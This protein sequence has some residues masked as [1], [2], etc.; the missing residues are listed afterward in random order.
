MGDADAGGGRGRSVADEH[1]L[2]AARILLGDMDVRWEPM[3]AG[4][5]ACNAMSAY[6]AQ[7]SGAGAGVDGRV[8]V[9]AG[10]PVRIRGR[11]RWGV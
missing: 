2:R 5:S 1:A 8:V 9:S 4:L 7:V 11:E 10:I 3:G 6:I